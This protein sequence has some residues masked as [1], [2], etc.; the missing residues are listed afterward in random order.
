MKKITPDGE[1]KRNAA[2]IAK[3]PAGDEAK[4][5]PAKRSLRRLARFLAESEAMEAASRTF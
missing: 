2:A 4:G 5:R 1:N 3:T